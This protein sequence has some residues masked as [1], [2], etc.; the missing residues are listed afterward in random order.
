MT[1]SGNRLSGVLLAP[2]APLYA[3]TLAYLMVHPPRR[4]PKAGDVLARW[5][6]E[7]WPVRVHGGRIELD[8]LVLPA[9]PAR[10]V[11]VGHGIGLDKTWSLRHAAMLR[12]AGYTV[13]LLDFRNHG[14][15]GD[16]RS[17]TSFSRRFTDDVLAVVDQVRGDERYQG[18][19]L[20]LF[21]F[22]FSTFPMLYAV[23]RMTEPIAAI[24]CDSGPTLDVAAVVENFLLSGIVPVPGPL[25]ARP[26]YSLLARSYGRLGAAVLDSPADWPPSVER[27]GSPPML[28]LVGDRDTIT[29]VAAVEEMAA[30]YPG[31]RVEVVPGAVH[32][33]GLRAGGPEYSTAVLGFLERA[34]TG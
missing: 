21:G 1:T 2:L 20:A 25:R 10:V 17:V 14:R 27:A 19:R 5:D 32:L 34:M 28:M 4:K 22:S 6:Q 18:A 9:D 12:E 3:L 8:L 23:S 30:R 24:V 11:V 7:H 29:P 26:A 16:D 13:V 31:A 15:S 33:Q